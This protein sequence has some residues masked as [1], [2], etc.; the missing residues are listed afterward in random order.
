MR[1]SLARKLSVGAVVA[2]FGLGGIMTVG[3]SG[4]SA[5]GGVAHPDH[6]HT[7]S[8]PA[9]GDV[10]FPLTDLNDATG[11]VV[12]TGEATE[13]DVSVTTVQSSLADL[14]SSPHAIVVH[15]SAE[16][17]GNY[18][19]CGN[20]AGPMMG[21]SDLPIGLAELNGSGAAGAALLHDNGDGTT[22]VSV[23]VTE[24]EEG[25][26]TPE[27]G[28]ATPGDMSGMDM[29]TPSESA[30]PS[31]VEVD[32]QGFSYGDPITIPVGTTVTFVNKDATAHTVT[33]K[34][35]TFQSNKI[36]PGASWSF[37]FDTAGTF[38]YFCEYHAN[39]AG[40]ITVQ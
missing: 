9:P 22:N 39:M 13:V 4:T 40:M 21:D 37:T 26:G 10:V 8:C 7:G 6:I 23:Y 2:A 20:V 17:I 31:A 15:E 36:D 14:V 5:H 34:G 35:G 19:L 16:N 1:S 29:G 32:I 12:G 24:N 30:S 3:L 28:A 11:N 18:I 25:Q 38:N 33:D 27:S